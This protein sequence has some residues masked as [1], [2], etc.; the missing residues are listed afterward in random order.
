[1]AAVQTGIAVVF[2]FPGT[3]AMVGIGSVTEA[4]A[5]FNDSGELSGDHTVDEVRDESN[6]VRTLVHSGEL[7][8]VT[9]TLT[10]RS[11]AGSNTLASAKT[12]LTK[13][14]LGTVVTLTGFDDPLLTGAWSYVGGFRNS[15]RKDGV[16]QYTMRIRKSPV[17]AY[18]ISTP[19]T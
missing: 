16:A 1:M 17:A 15:Y 14:T 8:E 2:G 18:D 7:L 4:N 19:V 3:I 12:S 13:P 6:D 5:F 10:P 11:A 9:L